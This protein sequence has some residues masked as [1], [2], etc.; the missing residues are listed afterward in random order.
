MTYW[1]S[2]IRL[3]KI[4][5]SLSWL[6]ILLKGAMSVRMEDLQGPTSLKDSVQM[7]SFQICSSLRRNLKHLLLSVYPFMLVYRSTLTLTLFRSNLWSHFRFQPDLTTQPTFHVPMSHLVN[8]IL[9]YLTFKT[10]CPRLL[11]TTSEDCMAQT[12]R[13]WSSSYLPG[14]HSVV[15]NSI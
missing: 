10:E 15:C 9:S 3:T 11:Q 13:T 6:V 5:D 1:R 14:I 2:S 4:R 7:F 12:L 8:C